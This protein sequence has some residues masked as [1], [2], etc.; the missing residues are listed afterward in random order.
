M[1]PEPISAWRSGRTRVLAPFRV[2]TLDWRGA[3]V[4]M[5]THRPRQIVDTASGLHHWGQRWLA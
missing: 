5:D 1:L 2:N 3:S 4:L